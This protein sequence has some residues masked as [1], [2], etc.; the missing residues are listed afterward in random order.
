MFPID[1]NSDLKE[2]PDLKSR[3]SLALLEPIMP[4]S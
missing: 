3:C 1:L 4:G 2:G